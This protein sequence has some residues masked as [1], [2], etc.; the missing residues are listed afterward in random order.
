SM[1]RNCAVS[2]GCTVP[3]REAAFDTLPASAMTVMARRCRNSR[4]IWNTPPSTVGH[5]GMT[6]TSH[7]DYGQLGLRSALRITNTTNRMKHVHT[8]GVPDTVASSSVERYRNL[9]AREHPT[10]EAAA[11]G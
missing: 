6:L 8:S 10:H 9:A 1:R 11:C 3:S 4:S 2:A 5:A 7:R